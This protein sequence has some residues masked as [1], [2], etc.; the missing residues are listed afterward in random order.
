MDNLDKV[1]FDEPQFSN[2]SHSKKT[3]KI[4]TSFLIDSRIVKDEKQAT[5]VLLGIVV[6][7]IIVSI[8]FLNSSSNY[9]QVDPN[10]FVPAETTV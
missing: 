5:Y 2:V 4:F 8:F 10:N 9:E 6:L 1:E 3:R 7:S